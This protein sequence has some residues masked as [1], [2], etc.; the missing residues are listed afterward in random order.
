MLVPMKQKVV[1]LDSF[2]QVTITQEVR[3]SDKSTY[4]VYPV[5]ISHDDGQ[6]H[7]VEPRDYKTSREEAEEIAK[8][9]DIPVSDSSAGGEAKVRQANELDQSIRDQAR[10]RGESIEVPPVPEGCRVHHKLAAGIW[11]WKVRPREFPR[12]R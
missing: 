7:V 6:F 2:N 11:S 4:T 8:F 1:P 5:R 3:R 12:G 10:N 9:L